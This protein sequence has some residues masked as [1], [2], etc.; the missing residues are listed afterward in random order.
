[1]NGAANGRAVTERT[2]V[3]LLTPRIQH[4][5]WPASYLGRIWRSVPS[6]N[7]FH[8]AWWKWR[9][10]V[11]LRRLVRLRWSS[12]HRYYSYSYTELIG[13]LLQ[14]A[15]GA[16]LLQGTGHCCL[17]GLLIGCRGRVSVAA[18]PFAAPCIAKARHIRAILAS[19]FPLADHALCDVKR[20]LSVA[21]LLGYK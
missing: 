20:L 6:T 14:G 16:S 2:L 8:W 1:M 13:A 7:F 10:E 15:P 3:S 9:W 12:N 18:C 11:F 17:A 4:T 19:L 21:R 5:D